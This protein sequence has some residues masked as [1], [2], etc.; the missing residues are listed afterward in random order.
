MLTT[1]H[2]DVMLMDIKMLKMDGLKA[3]RRIS[4]NCPAPVVILTAYDVTAELVEEAAEAGASAVLISVTRRRWMSRVWRRVKTVV[5]KKF[6]AITHL[7]YA[8]YEHAR[9]G[10]VDGEPA[11]AQGTAKRSKLNNVQ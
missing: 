1:C 2:F 4:A 3:T 10:Q 6:G 11:P 5:E 9:G 8:E 7:C